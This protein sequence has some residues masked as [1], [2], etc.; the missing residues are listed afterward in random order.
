MTGTSEICARKYRTQ[1]TQ[2]E[3]LAGTSVTASGSSTLEIAWS[4]PVLSAVLEPY[5]PLSIV[6]SVGTRDALTKLAKIS[7]T[8]MAVVPHL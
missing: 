1:I 3:G 4:R 6:C 2:R 8:V 5:S 7:T